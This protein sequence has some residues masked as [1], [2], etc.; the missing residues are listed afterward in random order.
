MTTSMTTEAVR[1]LDKPRGHVPLRSFVQKFATA[2][3]ERP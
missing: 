2:G 3:P 1:L